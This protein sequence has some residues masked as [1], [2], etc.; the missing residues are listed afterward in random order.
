VFVEDF[1]HG[2]H[3][4]A[5]SREALGEGVQLQAMKPYSSMQRRVSAPLSGVSCAPEPK[6]CLGNAGAKLVVEAV[7]VLGLLHQSGRRD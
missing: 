1:E 5:E 7:E 3:L 2:A 4:R 6:G